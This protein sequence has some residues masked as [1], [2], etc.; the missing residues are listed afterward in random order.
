MPTVEWSVSVMGELAA[1]AHRIEQDNEQVLFFL[2]DNVY[3]VFLPKFKVRYE[4]VDPGPA[5]PYKGTVTVN[6]RPQKGELIAAPFGKA[7]VVSAK[8]LP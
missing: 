4:Y 2:P 5:G 1:A 6:Y 7:V 8:K 3:R